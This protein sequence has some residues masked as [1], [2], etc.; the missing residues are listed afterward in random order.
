MHVRYYRTI[1]TVRK[2]LR[3]LRTERI[4]KGREKPIIPQ[5]AVI[6]IQT[7]V[8]YRTTNQLYIYTS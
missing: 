2:D 4:W 1:A 6:Q 7:Y 3:F 5:E 8:R